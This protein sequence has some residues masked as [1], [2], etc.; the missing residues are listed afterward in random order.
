LTA[1]SFELR[2]RDVLGRMGR[3]RT[4]SGDVETPA[5]MP[6]VN[7][8]SQTIPPKRML[9]EFGCKIIIAN[10]Y[11]IKK[12]FGDAPDLDVH[13]L[14]DYDGVVA[15]DSGAYQILVY[16][17]IEVS[18]EEVIGFQKLIGSDIGVILDIPT[19]WD[20]PRSR[21]EW[22]VEETIRRAKEALPLIRD[23][24]A[25][26]V[27]PVQ[28]G[29]HLDL[30]AR[31][32]R[33]IGSMPYQIHALGSP[34]E[35][36]E[37]YNF[38]VLVDMIM[39]AKRNLPPD[40]PLHLFGAGHPMMFAM[41]VALGCDLFDSASYALFARDGRYMTPRGTLRLKD[42]SHL[43]CSC[44]VCRRHGAD[45]LKKMIRGERVRRLAEHNLHVCMA[46]IET[47]KQAVVEGT[48][49]ELMEARSRGHPSMASALKRLS[50]Y[51]EDLER[52][53]P[54]YKG[55]AV[56]IYDYSSLSRP[57]VT[58]H[59]RLLTENY[60]R[61]EKADLLLLI[62]A[63]PSRPYRSSPQYAEL[64]EA[65]AERLGESSSRINVCFYAAPYGCVP[66][67]L[68]ETY[69]LSQFEVPEP[70]DRETLEFSAEKVG[71]YIGCSSHSGV[72]LLRGLGELDG[73][74]E[75]ACKRAQGEKLT[76][77]S[78]QNPWNVDA[79]NRLMNTLEKVLTP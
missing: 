72:V 15:T 66:A 35:V 17:G 21:V 36:M 58:R 50:M 33:A 57:E 55:R 22:T 12:H 70:P 56:F 63:P 14:L 19:G 11:L 3:L 45:E 44:P 27:G 74:V 5:F 24:E 68:S 37:R 51:R 28:G 41:S 31:S 34:T 47:I 10:A 73:L 67:E 77:L 8:L 2:D 60:V 40:R 25:L 18:Q 59:E 43:P 23:S 7:P 9:G 69:P 64:E 26:W 42:L 1:M 52:G 53:S 76:I 4:R 30:V 29:R 39:T 32:A 78:E 54:G 38:P 75:E 61:P 79:L 62:Q 13:R 65:L 71:A 20:I 46:E 6:V 49:W 48:L 16:G